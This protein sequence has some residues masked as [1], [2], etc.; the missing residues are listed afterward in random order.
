MLGVSFLSLASTGLLLLSP[1]KRTAPSQALGATRAVRR[2][3]V[4]ARRFLCAPLRSC[5]QWVGPSAR[6]HFQNS[7]CRV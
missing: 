3:A 7:K 6:A 2:A 5:G 1:G 4:E